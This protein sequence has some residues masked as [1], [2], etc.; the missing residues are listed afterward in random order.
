MG[1]GCADSNDLT[2][3][4]GGSGGSGGGN[5]GSTIDGSRGDG[6]AGGDQTIGDGGA[7]G[8]SECGPT[9]LCDGVD[10]NCDGQTDEGCDCQ[11]GDTQECFT[12]AP[13]IVGVGV[14][15]AGIQT[16]DDTGKWS[17]ECADEVLPS[18]ERC[19]GDDND[20]NGEADDG[21]DTQS[22]GMGLC[23]VTVPTCENGVEVEC[24]PLDPPDPTEDCDG[25]DDDCDGTADEGCVCE[26]G[27][28]QACYTGPE[29][30]QGVGLCSSGTQTCVNGQWGNCVGQVVPG[31]ELCDVIDQDCDN[32][33]SEGSCS[34]PNA[35]STCMS[36]GCVISGCTPGFDNCDSSMSNGCETQHTGSTNA[37]PGEFLGS[38]DADAAFGVGCGNAGC[39][40]PVATRTGTRG[41]H[42][43]ISALESSSCCAYVGMRFELVVPA[44]VDYDLFV[45]GNSCFADPGFA[46]V[47]GP[48]IN[49]TI[50]V[51]CDDG[52]F[53]EDTGFDAG[54]EVRY[55][56]GSSCEPWELRVYRR[57]C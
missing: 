19:D 56:G 2:G 51:W 47:N 39:Q 45:T 32:N 36:G 7:A 52:C 54:V 46:S 18:G 1:V 13:E 14:C 28:T 4:T 41:R 25:E 57:E 12:G 10:N 17:A 34:V 48:G 20:C 38:F 29:G 33:V 23:A 11:P 5:G 40:G 15:S 31:T 16:C 21:F 49:E 27:D 9:E 44:G 35:N 53:G 24:I 50:S 8:Q 30:T 55:Y 6:G 22:C 43:D 42:F 3:G 26:N 37:P